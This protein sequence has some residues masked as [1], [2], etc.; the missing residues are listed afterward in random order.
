MVPVKVLARAKS[1]LSEPAG[2]YRERLALAV[3]TDT[4]T[5]ALQSPRVRAVIVVTSDPVAAPALAHLGAHIVPD[6]AYAPRKA[7]PPSAPSHTLDPPSATHAPDLPGAASH[8]LDPSGAAHALDLPGAAHVLDPSGGASH[9]L[10]PSGAASYVLDPLNEALAYGAA[11]A[12]L[13]VPEAGV[14]ALSADLP[15]LRADE[16]TRVL[17]LAGEHAE[18]FVPDADET[19]TTMYATRP[20]VSFRPAYGPGSR[21]RHRAQGAHELALTDV[22][23]VRRD[24]DTIDHLRAALALGTGP[25]TAS[26]AALLP[27]A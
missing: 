20:G 12:R 13:L 5:A 2:P 21:D 16:L 8:A 14:A 17:D 19:G 1:R 4:V 22:P 23:S 18:S 24:V 26:V 10:D 9:V 27:V 3:A 11:R 6:P 15:A 7:D 25:H